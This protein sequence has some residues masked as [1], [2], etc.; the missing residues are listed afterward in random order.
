MSES[1][2]K[3]A[4][5]KEKRRKVSVEKSIEGLYKETFRLTVGGAGISKNELDLWEEGRADQSRRFRTASRDE[6]T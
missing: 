4:W 2:S 6:L 5:G 3:S 1:G